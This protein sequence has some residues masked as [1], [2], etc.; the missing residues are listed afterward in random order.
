MDK[1]FLVT[2]A[3]SGIGL[4][5]CRRVLAGGGRVFMADIDAKRV[6]TERDNFVNEYGKKAEFGIL[7]VRMEENWVQIWEQ[8]EAFFGH[9]VQGFCNNA[10][11]F[12]HTDWK[13]VKETNLDGMLIGAMLA[14]QRMGTRSGG[15]GGVMVMTGSICSFSYDFFESVPASVYGVTK[16]GIKAL[17]RGLADDKLSQ[18]DNVRTLGLCPWAVDTAL[19]RTLLPIQDDIEAFQKTHNLR[20]LSAAEIGKAFVQLVKEGKS[21][22]MLT[23]TPDATFFHPNLSNPILEYS[24][25]LAAI[26]KKVRGERIVKSQ[27]ILLLA[28]VLLLTAFL[29]LHLLLSYLGF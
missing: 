29:V 15:E 22:D 4:E 12:H 6:A 9:Q 5:M 10:G 7:D 3:A 11:I 13:K 27:D 28:G 19:V 25:K 2:G 20:I 14:F 21:G 1:D 16:H 26:A 18:I 8:A 23:I 17:V 24:T